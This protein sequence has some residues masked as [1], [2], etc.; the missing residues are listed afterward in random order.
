MQTKEFHMVE[1]QTDA[2]QVEPIVSRDVDRTYGKGVSVELKPGMAWALYADD[3][4]GG[5]CGQ[6]C[7]TTCP[8]SV[9][10]V[11]P[12]EDAMRAAMSNGFGRNR[13]ARLMMGVVD[14]WTSGG[15]FRVMVYG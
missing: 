7:R 8:H 11:W 6:S 14:D 3:G 10:A 5:P 9:L 4:P 1:K 12:N 2:A 13:K 15:N